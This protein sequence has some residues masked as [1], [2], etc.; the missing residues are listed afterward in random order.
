M[1]GIDELLSIPMNEDEVIQRD[2]LL[3]DVD[4]I[5]FIEVLD[6][7]NAL[8]VAYSI[9]DVSYNETEDKRKV[10]GLPDSLETVK[11]LCL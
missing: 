8:D 9:F 4:S 2:W 10:L 6:E 1:L 7:D 3:L 5:I 11:P